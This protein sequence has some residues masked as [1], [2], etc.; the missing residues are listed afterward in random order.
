MFKHVAQADEKLAWLWL[1]GSK[2]LDL[3][4]LDALWSDEV[5]ILPILTKNNKH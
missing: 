4:K 3:E 1:A 5:F 2:N